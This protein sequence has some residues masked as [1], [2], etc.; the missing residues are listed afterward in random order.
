MIINIGKRCF[1]WFTI[2]LMLMGIASAGFT[3][4]YNPFT[5]KLDF[6]QNTANGNNTFGGNNTFNGANNFT[7]SL[8]LNYSNCDSG[9]SLSTD[10][11]G[12]V[13][14]GTDD[15]GGAGSFD[16]SD[17]VNTTFNQSIGANKTFTGVTEI[18]TSIIHSFQRAIHWNNITSPSNTT[19]AC[20][21]TNSTLLQNGSCFQL[22]TNK[23]VGP[24]EISDVDYD[25]IC[26][27]GEVCLFGWN[28]STGIVFLDNL[29]D[30]VGIGGKKPVNPLTVTGVANA[31]DIVVH[32]AR[33]CAS[34]LA[35]FNANG[36]LFCNTTVL[37]SPTGS[38]FENEGY[39]NITNDFQIVGNWD[40]RK[41]V[42]LSSGAGINITTCGS[43]GVAGGRLFCNTT[44][45]DNENT[46]TVFQNAGYTNITNDFNVTGVWDHQANITFR[47]VTIKNPEGGANGFIIHNGSG[48]VFK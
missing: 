21:V 15:S 29:A 45:K 43:I 39:T 6:V 16:N 9:S 5:G 8:Y 31:S 33:N 27:P 37:Q 17:Y 47:N 48:L 32:N 38:S 28:R 19:T 42:N 11:S 7:N 41:Q 40:F 46:D 35:G 34:G 1:L 25:N 14:C 4:T 12:L 20:S 24:T 30:L 23:W 18:F 44:I 13:V 22:Q 2:A 10:S 36:S 26:L 3:T